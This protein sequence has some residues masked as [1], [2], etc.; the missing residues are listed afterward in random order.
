[1]VSR[2]SALFSVYLSL[3]LS[4]SVYHFLSLSFFLYISFFLCLSLARVLFGYVDPCFRV[5]TS[6]FYATPA[7]AR[8]CKLLVLMRY[9]QF[10]TRRVST[11]ASSK[12]ARV[13]PSI[14]LDLL[15]SLS[16]ILV[17]LLLLYGAF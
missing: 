5:F 10:S 16:L 14:Y 8:R 7:L 11:I 13:A 3:S 6:A 17:S 4:L 1:M 15:F 2:R 9:L 12:L